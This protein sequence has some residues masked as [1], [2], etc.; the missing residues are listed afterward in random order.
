MGCQ[1]AGPYSRLSCRNS[2]MQRGQKKRIAI[3]ESQYGMG[4]FLLDKAKEGDLLGEYV[5][6]IVTSDAAPRRET[7]AEH[8]HRNYAFTLSSLEEVRDIETKD[9]QE[10]I[11]NDGILDA[12]G[13]SNE[14]R[15]PN[16]SNHIRTRNCF[17]KTLL[18]ENQSRI[19]LYAERAIRPGQELLFDYGAEFFINQGG[20]PEDTN[21]DDDEI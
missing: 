9:R 20:R 15:F 17:A 1:C 12:I 16:H 18:I 5:G 21:D 11:D 14:T 2:E 3:R 6:D 19:G 8:K 13:I 4:A 7:V 10:V